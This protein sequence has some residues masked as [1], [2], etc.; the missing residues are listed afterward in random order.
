MW[1]FIW[2]VGDFS[3]PPQFLESQEGVKDLS[4]LNDGGILDNPLLSSSIAK[5]VLPWHSSGRLLL[6]KL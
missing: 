2:L 3:R 1:N 4:S 6:Q 5:D